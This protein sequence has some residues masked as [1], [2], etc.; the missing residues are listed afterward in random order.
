MDGAQ[1]KNSSQL[2]FN[3]EWRQSD[4]RK[5]LPT[6]VQQSLSLSKDMETIDVEPLP[7]DE[8]DATIGPE[9]HPS[10]EQQEEARKAEAAKEVKTE[11]A[12]SSQRPRALDRV[13][14]RAEAP[15]APAPAAPV[16]KEEPLSIADLKA[17][18]EAAKTLATLNAVWTQAKTVPKAEDA[19]REFY[20]ARAKAFQGVVTNVPAGW[21]DNGAEKKEPAAAPASSHPKDII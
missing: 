11:V 8:I 13:A 7:E 17:A 10:P 21:Q 2:G 16:S 9:F 5:L 1:R 15:P 3:L 4:Y 20:L 6:L 18:L 19:L 14:K 12:Q